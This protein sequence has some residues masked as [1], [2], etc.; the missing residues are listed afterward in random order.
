MVLLDRLTRQRRYQRRS[1]Q[2]GTLVLP[3]AVLLAAAFG[4]CGF[5]GY[6]LWP[7]WPWAEAALDAPSLPI[8]VADTVFHIP[9]AAVRVPVQR[10][11]G[12]HERVDLAFLWPSLDPADHAADPASPPRS[13]PDAAKRA[14]DRIFVTI[15]AA[16]D[17]LSPDER[18]RT[19][20]PRYA[21]TDPLP[22]PEGLAV[23]AFRA[24]TP[25]ECEDLIYDARRPGDFLV[26]CSR[27]AGATPGTCLLSRR[28]GA[29]DIVVRFPRDWLE[30]W[31]F[32]G[33]NVDRLISSIQ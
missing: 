9:P 33:D 13:P 29:A 16:A 25:Y 5:I 1:R 4:A 21:T 2:T 31:R 18:V 23:L 27:P 28:I 30:D 26:R 32:V 8:T 17:T 19:I 3:I 14:L 22:G 12:A 20:Y 7:S 11:A 6:A 15:A 24:G 10:R